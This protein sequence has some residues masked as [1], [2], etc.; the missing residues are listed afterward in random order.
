MRGEGHA[1]QAHDGWRVWPGPH[2]CIHTCA[3]MRVI[4]KVYQEVWTIKNIKISLVDIVYWEFNISGTF[5][6]V[7][8]SIRKHQQTQR[9]AKHRNDTNTE[10]TRSQTSG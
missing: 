7:Y 5:Q 10:T 4:S 9:E 6:F 2:M 8:V 1:T 3:Y